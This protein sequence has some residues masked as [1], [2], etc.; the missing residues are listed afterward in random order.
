MSCVS[1]ASNQILHEIHAAQQRHKEES[2]QIMDKMLADLESSFLSS[3]WGLTE[4][5]EKALIKLVENGIEE[6]DIHIENGL[7]V[8]ARFQEIIDNFAR[9]AIK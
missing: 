3:G 5:Q 6:S 1:H 9:I 8:D 4:D 2:K 7:R